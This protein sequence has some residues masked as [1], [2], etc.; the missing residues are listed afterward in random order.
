MLTSKTNQNAI[1]LLLVTCLLFLQCEKKAA[2]ENLSINFIGNYECVWIFEKGSD[3]GIPV[4]VTIS[5][6]N[7]KTISIEVVQF[8]LTITAECFT[9]NSFLIQKQDAHDVSLFGSGFVTNGYLEINL[10]IDKDDEFKLIKIAG[11]IV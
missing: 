11:N 4:D 9:K 1:I 5:Q 8:E 2:E 10:R 6:S 7:L 3:K